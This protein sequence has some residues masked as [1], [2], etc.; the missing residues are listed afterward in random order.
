TRIVLICLFTLSFIV[1]LLAIIGLV[2]NIFLLP[3]RRSLLIG[4]A[5]LTLI[6]FVLILKP[7]A[8]IVHDAAT[9]GRPNIILIGVDSLRPDFLS[10]FGH[11]ELSPHMDRFLNHATVFTESLT[12]LARTFPAWVSILTGTYPKKD[13]VRFNLAEQIN[14]NLED[15]LPAVLRQ[16]GYETIF[17]TDET[18]FSNVDQHFGFDQ[19]ITP[20]VGFND[21]LLGALSDFPLSNL[22]V[23]TPL[24]KYLFPHSYGNRPV[25]I[26][27]NPDSFLNLM[28]PTLEK[29]R[30]KPVFLAAHFCLAHFPYVWADRKFTYNSLA[31]YQA[32]VQ[33][34]DQQ[35]YGFLRLLKRN[36]LL[37]RSI[38]VLLS[39]HGEAIELS[40]DRITEA[41]LFM[42]Q[43][44]H[45]TQSI[46]TFYPPGMQ[47]EKVN[48]SAGHGTDVLGLPQ[49]H[50]LLAFRFFGIPNQKVISIAGRVSLL[51]LKPTLLSL[52]G[53]H[54]R[55]GDGNSLKDN[56]ISGKK[57]T[58]SFHQ[59]F[60]I[61]SDF[62]P[63]AVR[64]IHPETRKVL[65][66]GID[67]FEIN[68]LTTRLT[69]RK[70]MASLILSSKQYADFYGEWVLALYPQNKKT[71]MPILVNLETGQWTNDLRLSFAK[72]APVTHMINALKNFYGSDIT[73][74]K[75]G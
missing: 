22:L 32:A 44:T 54:V 71:M 56:I 16:H 7:S 11:K 5:S 23:N 49:Y 50:N 64:S 28:K 68:P 1:I 13:D 73:S 53:I 69:V 2:K 47:H 46:P 65:F 67:F 14:Y 8:P 75:N 61:E 18:R 59:D 27:Y 37:Q 15:T 6:L 26:T 33:R 36:N 29:P 24:G 20:P 55:K 3:L 25:F 17:A 19:V 66:E 38:V 58:V 31:N 74:I 30:T 35:V 21:F 60:F 62:S 51:D 41:D 39:D 42:R 63:E 10:Y 45:S 70:S 4:S 43:T 34:V 48:E 57:I 40:G 72:K 52:V 12:P 9:K